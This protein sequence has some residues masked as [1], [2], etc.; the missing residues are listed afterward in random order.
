MT[1]YGMFNRDVIGSGFLDTTVY[2]TSSQCPLNRHCASSRL[3]VGGTGF[4]SLSDE[5]AA[6]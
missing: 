6:N 4:I 1:K 2:S 3:V 5:E